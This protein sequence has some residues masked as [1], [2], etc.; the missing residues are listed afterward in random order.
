MQVLSPQELYQ[1]INALPPDMQEAAIDL[2]LDLYGGQASNA[3]DFSATRFSPETYIRDRLGWTPWEG[4]PEH[5]GQA[6][7]LEAYT[8]AL[9]Q[10]FE[11]QRYEAGE[12]YDSSVWTPGQVIKSR[13]RVESGDNNGK[14]KLA[15]GLASH[16]FDHFNPGVVYTFAPS[17][18]QVKRLLWKEIRA[19]RAGKNLPGKL[20]D[21]CELKDES[22]GGAKHFA[23]GISTDNAGGHGRENVQGEH[24]PHKL[25]VIDEAEGVAP[26]VYDAL[27]NLTSGG[28]WII[29]EIGNPM[30][31][32]SRFHK[33]SYRADCVT[34]RM[35]TAY[36][37]NVAAGR[38]IIPGAASRQFVLNML[39]DHCVKVDAHDPDLHTFELPWLPGAIYQPDSEYM[40]HVMGLASANVTDKNPVPVGRYEAARKRE[41]DGRE[42]HRA[43]LGIDC[44][45]WGRDNG[46]GYTN[47]AGGVRRFGQF[48]KQDSVSYFLATKA[49]AKR[50]AALGVTSLHVRVDAGGGFGAGVTDLLKYDDELIKLFA[51]YQIIEANFG[52][53][54]HNQAA[55][56]DAVTEWTYEAA[57][58]LKGL[59]LLN[60]P[61][62]LESDLCER[63]AE[64]RNVEGRFVRKL[65][66]KDK[67]RKRVGRSPDD[68][69]GFVLAVAP[70]YL[71]KQEEFAV[72]F[73]GRAK[74]KLA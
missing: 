18:K 56:Y 7:V 70:D 43:R 63:E 40:S 24:A 41:P 51:D 48:V 2:A 54:A 44:A 53:S 74:T 38:E 73:S 5:P 19:D 27:D 37:P 47:H 69:D 35:D 61:A 26:F 36:H 3:A 34:F 46:T 29:L 68:G 28:V 31:R 64:P 25:I 66:D 50:L 30:L 22:E 32:T 10:Q 59:A 67:F 9:R 42:P 17:W 20:L 23:V 1:R 12:G 45:R 8:L 11:R 21:N 13:I 57:E 49:E 33:E 55:Y 4:S 16:F 72:M 39:A 60:P 71:F 15:A 62:N 6:E 14:T 58:S 65:E 52:G